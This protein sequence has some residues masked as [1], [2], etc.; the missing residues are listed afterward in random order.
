MVFV[1]Y[2]LFFFFQL[3]VDIY[4]IS[5]SLYDKGVREKLKEVV[6]AFRKAIPVFYFE[7]PFKFTLLTL[8]FF[9]DIDIKIE[10]GVTCQGMQGPMYIALNLA[11]V[12]SIFVLLD[13]SVN[14]ALSTIPSSYKCVQS[15]V[16]H[17]VPGISRMTARTVEQNL[18][19]GFFMWVCRN[20][21]TICQI[22]I[23]KIVYEPFFPYWKDTTI[24]CSEFT[25]QNMGL[26]LEKFSQYSA[27]ILSYIL[28]W[29]TVHFWLHTFVYGNGPMGNIGSS[30]K[31]SGAESSSG[32]KAE[33][34]SKS[35]KPHFFWDEEAGEDEKAG[36]PERGLALK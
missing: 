6:R 4:L 5:E 14:S 31:N 29:P 28:F 33:H 1:A 2:F 9:L 27:T 11:V 35:F 13:T 32:A 10:G 3:I 15:T 36:T 17:R 18:V 12:S 7:W 21:R 22:L 34:P 25:K 26:D 30:S 23:A 24:M 16:V 19:Q 20:M 8:M